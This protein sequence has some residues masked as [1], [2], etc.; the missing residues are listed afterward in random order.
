MAAS[1]TA[2]EAG[3]LAP[4]GSGRR[5]WMS[6]RIVIRLS[7][8]VRYSVFRVPITEIISGN[9]EIWRRTVEYGTG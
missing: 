7:I 4:F 1:L 3:R 9:G 5:P 2:H 8:T 6:N